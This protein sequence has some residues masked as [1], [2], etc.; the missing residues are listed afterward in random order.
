MSIAVQK[1]DQSTE[2]LKQELEAFH[3]DIKDIIH[4]ALRKDEKKNG[5]NGGQDAS[6]G[7][8]SKG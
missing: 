4:Q 3:N 2:A 8:A 6:K 5:R 1:L 7:D